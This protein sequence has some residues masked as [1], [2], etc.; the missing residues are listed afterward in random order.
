MIAIIATLS[1]CIK[2]IHA[3]IYCHVPI[4]RYMSVAD[5][6]GGQRGPPPKILSK[7][8]RDTLIEQSF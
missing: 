6:G 8:D 7:Q 3:F 5:T 1:T 2:F 4:P